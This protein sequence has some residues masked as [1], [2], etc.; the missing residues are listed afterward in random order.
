M[1]QKR[2]VETQKNYEWNALAKAYERAQQADSGSVV[3]RFIGNVDP[4]TTAAL[5]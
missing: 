1:F 3:G 2:V 4:K 5:E